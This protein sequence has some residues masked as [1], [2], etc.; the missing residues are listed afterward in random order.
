MCVAV[1]VESL[2]AVEAIPEIAAVEV[3]RT[4]P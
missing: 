1:Q 4:L 2:S 3:T